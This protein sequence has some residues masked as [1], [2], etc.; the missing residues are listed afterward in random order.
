MIINDNDTIRY[1]KNKNDMKSYDNYCIKF[2]GRLY[3]LFFL[4]FYLT[5]VIFI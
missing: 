4:L 2:I 3:I 5:F 1:Y